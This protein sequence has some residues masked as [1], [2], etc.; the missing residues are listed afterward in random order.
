MAIRSARSSRGSVRVRHASALGLAALLAA[1]IVTTTST[2]AAAHDGRMRRGNHQKYKERLR[3]I[4]TGKSGT[5]TL[6]ARALRGPQSG[7]T[8]VEVSTAPLD[9]SG[10][11]TGDVAKVMLSLLKAS[12][13]P[14]W[15]DVKL[16]LSGSRVVFS[17]NRLQRGQD[18]HVL[19]HVRANVH[20]RN[21][22][23]GVKT[24]VFLRPDLAVNN[25]TAPAQ[26]DVNVPANITALVS[27]MNGDVGARANCLLFVDG[28]QKDQAMGIWV[29]GGSAVSCAFTQSFDSAGTKA[30]KVAV[31]G[32]APAEEDLSNNAQSGS[33]EV[34][35]PAPP[36]PAGVPNVA[37]NYS[38]QVTSVD[39]LFHHISEGSFSTSVDRQDWGTETR[40]QGWNESV[41]MT[42]TRSV[43]LGPTI[44]LTIAEG[45][46]PSDA[47]VTTMAADGWA[48]PNSSGDET[49][50][51][52]W[53]S[54]YDPV[55]GANLYLTTSWSPFGS[56]F[57]G[58]YSRFAG[59]VVYYS[60]SFNRYWHMETGETYTYSENTTAT[61]NGRSLVD[62]SGAS[63]THRISVRVE[64][65]TAAYVADPL[66]SLVPFSGGFEQPMTCAVTDYGGG[67]V[68]SQCDEYHISDNGV[69]GTLAHTAE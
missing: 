54:I 37:M 47:G 68:Y 45:H 60:R 40:N 2:A 17:Y 4:F 64:D 12:G 5:V 67:M 1:P 31:A 11:A 8:E 57:Q 66:I 10:G 55:E 49:A 25:L 16:H 41:S 42:F 27:E 56:S 63:E 34:Q 46:G 24:T 58:Q 7:V 13:W 6:A 35:Q 32:A 65:A 18:L 23:V 44:K 30:I 61:S 53:G 29:D 51:T 38:A 59:E 33:I 69:S 50:G 43:A 62:R 14:A 9:G 26:V 28:V 48:F 3:S 36:P 22:L 20:R 39:Q 52:R 21:E 19:A 15:V